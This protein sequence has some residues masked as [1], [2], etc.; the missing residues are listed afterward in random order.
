MKK[1][2]CKL[3][4]AQNST[5]VFIEQKYYTGLYHIAQQWEIWVDN[6]LH[7]NITLRHLRFT[8]FDAQKC[9]AGKV[10]VL[11]RRNF[12]YC[13]ILSNTTIY[14]AQD[15]GRILLKVQSFVSYGVLL[16]Y[17][18]IDNVFAS[19][20]KKTQEQQEIPHVWYYK[21]LNYLNSIKFIICVRKK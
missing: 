3:K 8:Y 13:G 5:K 19:L 12:V 1:P 10:E 4:K 17:S 16:Y 14:P 6:Y 9:F 20:L 11:G 2:A 7:V 18:V 21:T 15:A